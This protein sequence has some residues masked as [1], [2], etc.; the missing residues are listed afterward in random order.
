MYAVIKSGGKQYR[1]MEGQSIRVE[2]LSADIGNEIKFDQILM[3]GDGDNIK[4]GNGS[5]EG[6][7]VKAEVVAHGREDKI[8]IIKLKRRKHHLKTMGHRQWYT[9][10]KITSILAA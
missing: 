2:K 4:I 1:V 8:R 6:C 9:E 7:T 5:L 10:L 3:L